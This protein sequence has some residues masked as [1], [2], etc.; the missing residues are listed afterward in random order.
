MGSKTVTGEVDS[1]GPLGGTCERPIGRPLAVDSTAG[2]ASDSLPGFLAKPSDA[3]VY[4]GFRVLSDVVVD[5]F[6][7]GAIT[8]FEVEP[9]TE[10]D[11]FVVAPDNSRAGLVLGSLGYRVLRKGPR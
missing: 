7:L 3:P 4:H 11:S 8:D 6:T 1:G 5:G 2:S 10:G 9:T